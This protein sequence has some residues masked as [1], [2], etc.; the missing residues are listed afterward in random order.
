VVKTFAW[1]TFRCARALTCAAP[2]AHV[3]PC[4]ELPLLH[5]PTAPHTATQPP[6]AAARCVPVMWPVPPAAVHATH[7]L[8]HVR[9]V[10]ELRE[11]DHVGSTA[12]RHVVRGEE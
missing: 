9:R 1:P 7:E 12:A 8:P 3:A 11:H 2:R 10:E 5:H 6:A 4:T